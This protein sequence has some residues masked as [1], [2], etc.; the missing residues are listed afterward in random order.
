MKSELNVLRNINNDGNTTQRDI[1]K[2]TGMS[3]GNVNILIK[4]LVGKGLLKIERLSPKTIKYILTPQG[5]KEKAEATYKYI[6]SSCKLINRLDSEIDSL[7]ENGSYKDGIILFGQR[8]ELCQLLE[9]KLS[10]NG[11]KYLHIQEED[12]LKKVIEGCSHLIFS[13]N[14]GYLEVAEKSR[15]SCINILHN[16]FED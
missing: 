15:I 13:W 3:L 16:A 9:Q 8:D 10:Q 4:R 5:I 2:I 7:L 1:A 6:L 14:P 12:V 11:I